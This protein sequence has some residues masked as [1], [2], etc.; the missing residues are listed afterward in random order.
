MYT[1]SPTRPA[2]RS[3][4][5]PRRKLAAGAAAVTVLMLLS[6][7][8]WPR[9]QPVATGVCVVAVDADTGTAQLHQRYIQWLAP[10]LHQC[11][12]T[13]PKIVLLPVTAA[14]ET[15]IITPVTVDLG[16]AVDLT[17]NPA[18]V[19][20]AVTAQINRTVAAGAAMLDQAALADNHTG[21][22]LVALGRTVEQLFTGSGPKSL[23]VFSDGIQARYPYNLTVVPL[24]DNDR[25]QYLHQLR[26]AHELG[27]LTGVTV[28]FY[29]AGIDDTADQLPPDRLAAIQAWWTDYYRASG[30]DLVLYTRTG[31]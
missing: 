25:A 22:D 29:G 13:F 28:R 24:G 11:A 5:S 15:T 23:Y 4:L 19:Q 1:N 21:T 9:P 18:N 20:D 7:M 16:T 3:R 8:F 6:W 17:G 27:N 2:T 14:T 26:D 31:P 30:A 10:V 12:T